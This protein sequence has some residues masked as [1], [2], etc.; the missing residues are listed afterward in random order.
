MTARGRRLAKVAR[1][2]TARDAHTRGM[3]T[4]LVG[5]QRP[6][7]WLKNLLRTAESSMTGGSTVA[8]EQNHV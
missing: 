4:A 2:L 7:R 5:G 3:L 8:R 1:T 6:R